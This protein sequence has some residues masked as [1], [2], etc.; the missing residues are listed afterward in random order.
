MILYHNLLFMVFGISGTTSHLCTD[1]FQAFHSYRPTTTTRIFFFVNNFSINYQIKLKLV[2]QICIKHI[3]ELRVM[4]LFQIKPMYI[5]KQTYIHKLQC[6][7]FFVNKNIYV[8]QL[9]TF[10]L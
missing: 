6:Q 8:S 10:A 3:F 2:S 7:L 4:C 1:I 9:R 5:R